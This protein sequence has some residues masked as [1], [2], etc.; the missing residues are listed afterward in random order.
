VTELIQSRSADSPGVVEA[1]VE[2][3]ALTVGSLFSGIG[4]FELGFERAG[5][6]VKWQVEIDPFCRKVLE[7][8]WPNV[9]RFSDVREC[10][11]L[12]R[13]DVITGGFPCQ[14][15]S[16]AARGKVL[17][18]RDARFLWPEMRRIIAE[19]RPRV[20]VAENV[21][22]FAS[23][24]LSQVVYDL[25]SLNYEVWTLEIPACAFGHDHKRSRLWIFG[26]TD[27]YRKPSREINAEASGVQG[28]NCDSGG[29]GE[30]HGISGRM[31]RLRAV[32]NA[33][34]PQISEWIGRI[35][36]KALRQTA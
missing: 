27:L 19:G 29:V 5:M 22:N 18:T 12:P 36:V 32:G 2:E 7:R 28:N 31:D 15:F 21:V 33:V 17:G 13:V 6:K 30:A 3:Q 10:R 25:E 4:G 14:P 11:E 9:Q 34:V 26:Y 8:H 20:V 24:G 35:I 16:S 1:V 23:A